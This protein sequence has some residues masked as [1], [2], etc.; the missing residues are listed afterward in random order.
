V[1]NTKP[2]P[3]PTKVGKR[4]GRGSSQRCLYKLASVEGEA[5]ASAASIP[6]GKS[7]AEQATES[8]ARHLGLDIVTVQERIAALSSQTTSAVRISI[9][10]YTEYNICTL[11]PSGEAEEDT[12]AV[13]R[14]H[15][16]HGVSLIQVGGK[17]VP[18]VDD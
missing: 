5:P 18:V 12:W 13:I 10:A 16:Q 11:D 7:L 15:F 1:R 17:D 14:T 3:H 4:R 6:D 8:H 9:Q 2:L